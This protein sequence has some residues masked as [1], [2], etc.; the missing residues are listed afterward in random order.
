MPKIVHLG[1]GNFHRAHQAWYTAQLPDWTITAVVMSN[2]GLHDA[3][4]AQG[5]TYLLG[6]WGPDGLEKQQIA[7]IKNT[8][9]APTQ[10]ALIVDEIAQADTQVITLTLTEKGYYLRV[11]GTQLA[12]DAAPIAAD[13][14][15]QTPRTALGLLAAGL[16][17]R[18][19]RHGGPITVISCDNL[20]DN[21]TKLRQALA[22]YVT[23]K[24]PGLLAWLDAHVSFP[25]TMVDRITPRLSDQ[26][27]A[28]MRR[29]AGGPA[30]P[31]VGTEAFSEWI[32]QDTFKGARPPWDRAGAR[33]VSDIH[34]FE[35]RK[36]RLLNAAH[37]YLAY[38][39]VLRGYTFIHE[40]VADEVLKRTMRALWDEAAA[41]LPQATP[42]PLATYRAALEARFAVPQ[43]RHRLDQIATDG[44]LKLPQRIV[45]TIAARA[46]MGLAAPQAEH[47]LHCWAAYVLHR[48]RTNQPVED[49]QAQ[50]LHDI[51]DAGAAP[52]QM[53][54]ALIRM[55]Q[56]P[57]A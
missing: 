34:Q 49:A 30:L 21:G 23:L 9:F 32:I 38:A 5:H 24:E 18:A 41:T 57:A 14:A 33:F 46:A 51:Y 16:S 54:Q 13:L 42:A 3:M 43:V 11:D 20:S 17:R 19:A 2:K 47:V 39:G 4:A 8:L 52:Q 31:A 55:I 50:H 1:L 48:F 22:D 15:S 28:D 25:N 27:V 53:R 29:A 45:P 36:L 26:A 35:T 44:T 6:I 10:A 37:S 7:V 40:A 12:Q 56:A